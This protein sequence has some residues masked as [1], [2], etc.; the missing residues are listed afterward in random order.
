MHNVTMAMTLPSSA[1]KGDAAPWVTDSE[2][3]NRNGSS[4]DEA[5]RRWPRSRISANRQQ[6]GRR[7]G[8]GEVTTGHHRL[9]Q[10]VMLRHDDTE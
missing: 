2:A 10:T 4:G 5:Q 9:A 1:D 8:C 6:R 7:H 3:R